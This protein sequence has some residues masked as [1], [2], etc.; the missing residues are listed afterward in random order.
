[1]SAL[2]DY[3]GPMTIE[4]NW[5]GNLTYRASAVEHPG[6][7]DELRH[8]LARGGAARILGSRHCFNDIADTDGLLIALDRLP[9]VFEVN[10]ARDA[11]RVS[12]GPVSY[13]HLTLPTIYSV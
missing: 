10:D 9:V 11:V 3:Y 5:A 13:T 2:A 12:G 1:M 6:S 4:R 7:I 8:L